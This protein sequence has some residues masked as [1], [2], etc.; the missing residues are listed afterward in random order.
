MT[1]DWQMRPI[2]VTGLEIREVPDGYVVYDA[3]DG[4]LHYL[5]ATAALLLEACD[6]NTTARELC[7]LLAEAFGL[8]AAP[9]EEV[10]DCLARLL[11]EGLLLQAHR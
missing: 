8:D 4:K 5:N 3:Q 2:R 9:M 11:A 10:E 1:L 6:G 7:G